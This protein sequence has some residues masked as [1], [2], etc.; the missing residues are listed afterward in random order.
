APFTRG[1]RGSEPRA[2]TRPGSSTPAT[3]RRMGLQAALLRVVRILSLVIAAGALLTLAFIVAQVAQH[4]P[5]QL[6]R[7]R[8][9]TWA[10]HG[11]LVLFALARPNPGAFLSRAVERVARLF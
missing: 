8:E 1:L 6:H 5:L 3:E 7:F 2:L 9:P 11:A 10:L 4:T